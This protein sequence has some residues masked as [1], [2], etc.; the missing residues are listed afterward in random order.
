[1]VC[2]PRG[3]ASKVDP[4][5]TAMVLER[6]ISPK[7]WR[8][9]YGSILIAFI[10]GGFVTTA[11]DANSVW[12]KLLHAWRKDFSYKSLGIS[13]GIIALLSLAE[14]ILPA[15][16]PRKSPKRYLLNFELFIFGLLVAAPVFGAVIGACTALLGSTLGLG[17]MDLRFTTGHGAG[18]LILAF[19]LS[20]LIFDFFYYWFHRFQH[21]SF[22]WHEH[23]LHH[24]DEELCAL[25]RDNP[26]E[27]LLV[28]GAIVPMVILFK[29]DPLQGALLGYASFTWIMLIHTNIRLPLGWATV[30]FTGPQLHRIHHSRLEE[31]FDRNFAAF[32]PMWDI[33]FGT[34]F[35]PR[36]GE[37]PE[38]GVHDEPE[39]ESFIAA[40][41]LPF[42]SWWRMFQRWRHGPSAP[43][44][45]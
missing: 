27:G 16:G 10:A 2:A 40:A 22:L 30:L 11:L 7:L 17:W 32:F 28:S 9:A 20:Q 35:H 24:M 15:A 8:I 5:V 19:L 18:A 44:L 12:Q 31:H 42:R 37:Y 6:F 13:L 39:V 43:A 3:A 36:P 41:L 34:Y 4:E 23:K 38:T 1:M 33:L 14:R 26:L 21:E 29:L 25:N 45:S